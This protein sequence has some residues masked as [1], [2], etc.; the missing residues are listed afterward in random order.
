M[1]RQI[2]PIGLT[3]L[4]SASA[5]SAATVKGV[6]RA[7]AGQ[8]AAREMALADA[9]RDAVR[10]GAGVDLISS[11]SVQDFEMEYDEIFS[12][13]V[14]YIRSY[15]VLDHAVDS[16][17]FYRVEV[18]AD[19]MPGN[20]QQ[21]DALA[22]R[23][24][25]QRVRSPRIMVEADEQL[26]GRNA[27]H[28]WAAAAMSQRLT[29]LGFDVIRS[30]R[31]DR[32]QQ[33]MAARE[34]LTGR[35]KAATWRQADIGHDADIVMSVYVRGHL[36]GQQSVYGIEMREVQL[37]F[38]LAAVWMDTGE[39]IARIAAPNQTVHTQGAEASAYQK[40]LAELLKEKDTPLNS[41]LKRVLAGWITELDLGA[42]VRVEL[43]GLKRE[44]LD[45]LEEA[46][47]ET[48]GIHAVWVRDFDARFMSVLDVETRN[49]PVA[50]SAEIERILG[51]QWQV[52]KTTA[53]SV[54]MLKKPNWK[55]W[56][57]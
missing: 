24:L 31:L 21:S 32:H 1:I 52:D 2:G 17:G 16:E 15:R 6:G 36:G 42:L 8:S 46:L 5:L 37:G 18:M 25:L 7:P 34:E 43:E 57:K 53:R 45:R 22:I 19:V 10:K 38:D 26:D 51:K 33:K 30:G 9:L 47:R 39:E 4:L 13:S 49:S 3:V 50:L 12:S 14:G 44:E 28:G 40:A 48:K 20:P 27:D 55:F 29:E 41:L 56:Q 23:Q 35:K 54:T 11:V